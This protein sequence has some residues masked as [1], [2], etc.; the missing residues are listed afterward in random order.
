[1]TNNR[2]VLGVESG[3][4][5]DKDEKYSDDLSE[6]SEDAKDSVVKTPP[7]SK[8]AAA[9]RN[10]RTHPDREMDATRLY[11]SEIGFSSLLTG[12]WVWL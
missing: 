2:E 6:E 12:R 3:Q 1:M 4:L 5:L 11:L 8:E 9:D 7:Y 10:R